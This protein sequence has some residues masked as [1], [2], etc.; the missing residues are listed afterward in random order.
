MIKLN[1]YI[2]EAWS[3]VKKQSYEQEIKSWC[4]EMGIKNYTIN[5][6]GEIDVDDDV[7]LVGTTFKELPYKFGKVNGFFEIENNSKLTSLKNCPNYVMGY[8]SCNYNKNLK[9]LEGCPKTVLL[10][11]WCKGCGKFFNEKYIRSMCPNLSGQI[12]NK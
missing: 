2:N 5:S 12:F 9:S 11:F 10:S 8:F 7:I 6:Q 3:G 1:T 4:D